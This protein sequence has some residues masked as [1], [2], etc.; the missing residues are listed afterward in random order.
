MGGLCMPCMLLLLGCGPADTCAAL[1]AW[2]ALAPCL[3]S[4]TPP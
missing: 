3:L 4:R 2:W 1:H